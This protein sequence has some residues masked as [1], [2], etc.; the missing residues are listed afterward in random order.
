MA[1]TDPGAVLT[2]SITAEHRHGSRLWPGYEL[3]LV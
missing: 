3:Y 1:F 2:A